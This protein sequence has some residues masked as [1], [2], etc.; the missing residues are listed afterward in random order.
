M[1]IDG[2]TIKL[3]RIPFSFFL[4]PLFLFAY[5]QADTVVHRQA[6]FAFLIIHLL[7]Y[8]ASNGYNSYVDRDED[9]I[10]GLEKPPMP[11]V[12]LFYLT[13]FLDFTAIVLAMLFVNT[14]FA[15]C[16]LFYIAA[17]RAY[18]SRQIRL[19]K[20]PVAGFLVV[21][22]FQGAFTYYMSI[23]GVS[24]N[25][26]VLNEEHIYVLLGCS[27]QI[28]GAYP[29]TQIYQHKQ[30]LKDGVV[31]LSYKLGYI[32]TFLFT[33]LMFLLCNVF[34]YLYFTSNDLGMVFYIIQVFFAPIV[35]Y[36][37]YWF[38]KVWKDRSEANFRNTMRM[39]WIAAICMNSCFI[40]LIIINR[41]PLSYISAIE[42]AVPEYCYSQEALASFYLKSTD[43]LTNKR[44]IKIVAG[45]T[46]IDN[47]YSVIA[48]F[49]KSPED[50][51]F[52]NKT[53]TLLPEPTL[54]KRMQIYQRHATKLS[55]SAIEKIK[56][57]EQIKNTLTHLITVTC[58]GL[59]APGLDVELMRELDLNPTIQRSSVN[60]M[61]CNAAI[62]ALKN[63]D[64]ICKSQPG[65]KVLV[66]C[67]E[68]CT[69]HF[70]KRY[71]DDYLLSNLIFGDG[72]AAVLVT[73]EPEQH[74]LQAVEIDTFNSLIL[75]NGYSDM[76]W[77]LSET[78]FIMNLSSYVPDLIRKNIKPMMSKI[79][80]AAEDFKHWAV[81]PGGKR[82]VDDFA[83]ALELDKCHLA[84]TYQVLK[85]YGNMSSPTVLFVLKEVLEKAK[86]ENAGNRIF[87]AA[88]GPGLSIETMQ[89]HYV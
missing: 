18:S 44:K 1:R 8:P 48:D 78:G 75:H 35:L 52:F 74:Y 64:A 62:I 19:K 29:L 10:G 58:T 84:P 66:V 47:R 31:T 76:A 69:I 26:L 21:V 57:F 49:D 41:I 36:F 65:A 6:L 27:F 83:A 73:A 77:Q 68:L 55:R 87:T 54:S 72:S 25:A 42:T 22:I 20:Y 70:Q 63:A 23:A 30:D 13:I 86:P 59:F 71:N 81:H 9:S 33:A 17:S 7:I 40:V 16:L 60:F 37:S 88:F 80:L 5:S 38:Y 46:G 53:A 34:Y 89:L 12:S 4:M 50:Y 3:L 67:T 14:L 2:N 39:N 24:G 82:I 51:E 79:G 28:A 56:G 43:D 61:G 11:T 32:G 85:N 15:G 45:K